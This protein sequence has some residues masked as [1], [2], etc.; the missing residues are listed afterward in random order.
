MRANF[1]SAIILATR[2]GDHR[3]SSTAITHSPPA[4]AHLIEHAEC[5]SLP[6]TGFGRALFKQL[7]ELLIGHF[8][9][10]SPYAQIGIL[11]IDGL[12]MQV[13]VIAKRGGN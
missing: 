4:S 11:A 9:L 13:D 5:D 6:T 7:S 8:F 2:G 12:C 1:I 3:A 10:F